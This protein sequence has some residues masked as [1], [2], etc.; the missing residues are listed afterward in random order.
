MLRILDD[1][2]PFEGENKHVYRLRKED[3]VTLPRA[4]ASILVRRKKAIEMESPA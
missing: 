1:I 4:I 2:P 3:V